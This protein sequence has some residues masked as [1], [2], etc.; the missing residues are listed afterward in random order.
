MT[1]GSPVDGGTPRSLRRSPVLVLPLAAAFL[2]ASCGADESGSGASTGDATSSSASSA[3]LD[4][5]LFLE[6]ALATEPT[7][8]DCTLG[9][10]AETTC[11]RLTVAG[12]PTDHEVGPFCPATITDGADAGGIWFDGENQYD[13]SGEF[14]KDLATTYDDETWK[15]YDDEGNV[16][17]TETQEEFEAAARPDVDPALQNHCVQGKVDWLDRR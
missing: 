10:G 6:G 9:G 8:E 16:L 7:T 3:G 4:T 13:I 11:Y 14:I 17:V 12:Y 2:L 1:Q 5:G 15:M